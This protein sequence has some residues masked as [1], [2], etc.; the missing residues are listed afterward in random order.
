MRGKK[1]LSGSF[2]ASLLAFAAVSGVSCVVSEGYYGDPYYY[3]PPPPPPGITMDRGTAV[4]MASRLRKG[5][6]TG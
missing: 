3:G 4:D 1:A 6:A 2:G 5:T